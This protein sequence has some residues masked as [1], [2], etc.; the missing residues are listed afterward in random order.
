MARTIIGVIGGSTATKG[1]LEA[2]YKVGSLLAAHQ[3]V[4]VCGGMGGVM[5][6]ACRGAQENGGLT[7][8]ILPGSSAREGNRYLTIP[9]VTGL[10]YARNAVVVQTSQ[11]IIAIGGKYGTLSELAYAAQYGIPLVGLSTWKVRLPIKHVRT[12][13]EAVKLALQLAVER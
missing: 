3:A 6:A 4:L 1:Q 2:A 10:G 8:G 11:A 7:V 12:P 5:E 9:I 13:S